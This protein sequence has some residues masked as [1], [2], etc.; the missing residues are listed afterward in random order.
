M[1]HERKTMSGIST[2]ALHAD[3]KVHPTRAVAPPIYQTATFWAEDAEQLA[4]AAV[5]RRG[6]RSWK[7]PR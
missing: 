5:N 6:I 2:V 7:G 4:R 3:R 1:V